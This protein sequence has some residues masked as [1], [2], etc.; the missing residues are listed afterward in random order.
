MAPH[1]VAKAK[2]N[3]R[4]YLAG[5]PKLKSKAR[6]PIHCY[7]FIYDTPHVVLVG[8]SDHAHLFWG[9][10]SRRF[11]SSSFKISKIP[12]HRFHLSARGT[13][14]YRA[15]MYDTRPVGACMAVVYHIAG[16]W[17]ILPH[18]AVRVAAGGLRYPATP[19]KYARP[20]GRLRRPGRLGSLANS[21]WYQGN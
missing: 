3:P 20:A 4:R 17:G 11:I 14:L 19:A 7:V 9:A 5:A 13:L 12:T 16:L 8:L 1:A 15:P 6:P 18:G 10:C 2:E 21:C